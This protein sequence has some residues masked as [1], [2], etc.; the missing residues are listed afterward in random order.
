MAS[1]DFLHK[2]AETPLCGRYIV[3]GAVCSF[4]TNSEQLLEVAQGTFLR[5]TLRSVAN[6]FSVRLWVDDSDRAHSPWPKPYV[7]GLDHLVFAGFD[8]GSSILADLRSR[9][10]I[11][12]FSAGMAADSSY[13]R[14]VIFPILLS[15]VAGSIG[16]VELHAACVARDRQGLV[17]I[18]PS[19]SGKSTLAMALTEAGFGLLSDDRTFCS[20]KRGRLIAWGIRR[21]L[22]LRPE[23]AAW[24]ENFRGREP[25]DFQ[26]G[27]RVFHCELEPRQGGTVPAECEPRAL[28]FL[29]R[30]EGPGYSTTPMKRSEARFRIETGLLA[31]T[32]DAVKKQAATIDRLLEIPCWSLRYGGRPQA[33]A[34]QISASFFNG[35]GDQS[36]RG[37][38]S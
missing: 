6:D 33:I 38:T 5:A 35:S 15:V 3:A 30:Q 4:S 16:I 2:D 26:D 7:R 9:R 23:A 12:R 17:L 14:M 10:V 25:V 37:M 22:K 21:P 31:E 28:V 1:Q 13:W 24:F 11:G 20:F 18:G 8:A 36:P 27:E 32:P 19:R 34:E 29:N